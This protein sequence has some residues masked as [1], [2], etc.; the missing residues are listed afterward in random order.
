MDLAELLPSIR[1]FAVP[2]CDLF[3]PMTQML[4]KLGMEDRFPINESNQGPSPGEAFQFTLVC[5]FF[6]WLGAAR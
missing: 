3:H 2:L 5:P 1:I 6:L 4:A